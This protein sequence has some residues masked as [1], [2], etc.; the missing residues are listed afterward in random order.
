MKAYIYPWID[1][2][3]PA[4]FDDFIQHAP[5]IQYIED[6]YGIRFSDLRLRVERRSLFSNPRIKQVD[7]DYYELY[8]SGN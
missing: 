6:L 5:Y 7:P 3:L 2:H 4:A 1:E 8:Y